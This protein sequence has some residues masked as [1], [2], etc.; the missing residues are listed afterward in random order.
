MTV[1]Q[2][3]SDELFAAAQRQARRE[4]A[5]RRRARLSGLAV[6][7][8][9]TLG[10]VAAAATTI[11]QPQLGDAR[12]GYPTAS[13]SAP[14]ADQ[15][16]DLGV[17]RRAATAADH[18]AQSTYALRFLD[19]SLH[20][21]RT[22]YVRLLGTQTNGKGF[23]LV[24]VQSYGATDGAAP[25]VAD[26]LCLFSQ[27]VEGGGISC[28][29][30]QQVLAGRA[31]MWMLRMARMAPRPLAPSGV[32]GSQPGGLHFRREQLRPTTTGGV[33]FGLVPDGVANVKLTNNQGSVTVPVHDNFFQAPFPSGQT[34]APSQPNAP[35]LEWLDA[36]G[37]V[38]PK[39]AAPGS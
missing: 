32:T 9:L 24:P 13:S 28:F 37:N 19:P 8:A 2:Q 34:G 20:G 29:N 22:D 17:L 12:R 5:I 18:G 14:P 35:T 21:V 36:T 31:V 16:A 6:T 4:T 33:G 10:G 25:P 3:F 26:A 1:L 15:L 11:W 7:G 27:D 39:L 30:T 23:V 38:I